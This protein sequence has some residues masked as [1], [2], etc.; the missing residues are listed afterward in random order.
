MLSPE[1]GNWYWNLQIP[2]VRSWIGNWKSLSI[3]TGIHHHVVK[4]LPSIPSSHPPYST[5][6]GP[7]AARSIFLDSLSRMG[8]R[9]W[10]RLHRRKLLASHGARRLGFVFPPMSSR[11]PSTVLMSQSKW[12]C[13]SRW[14]RMFTHI[15]IPI[16]PDELY[17]AVE[18]Q[19]VMPQSNR[20][21]VYF[22]SFFYDYIHP[23][24]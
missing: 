22:F 4:P 21:R 23:V 5:C 2:A 19:V 18:L 6:G 24:L 12:L 16:Q 10:W 1:I 13:L 14:F 7:L 3:P 11:W 9:F 17:W 15:N 8:P 20:T